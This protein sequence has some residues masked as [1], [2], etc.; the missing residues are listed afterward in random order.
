[1]EPVRRAK[2]GASRKAEAIAQPSTANVGNDDQGDR[3]RAHSP[4]V[5]I[6]DSQPPN[7]VDLAEL[8]S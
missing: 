3:E 8:S 1:M 7:K 4:A 5:P 2:H 6:G